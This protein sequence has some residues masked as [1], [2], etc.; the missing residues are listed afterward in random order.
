MPGS[1]AWWCPRS[2]SHLITEELA[3]AVV[4]VTRKLPV[5]ATSAEKWVDSEAP[6]LKPGSQKY[7]R[8]NQKNGVE[9]AS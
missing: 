1:A 7:P 4:S 2:G 6:A 8:V 3:A 9:S 5:I